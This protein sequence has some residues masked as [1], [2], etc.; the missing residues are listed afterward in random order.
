MKSCNP[1]LLLSADHH[2]KFYS[3]ENKF[4]LYS[5][6]DFQILVNH[7]SHLFSLHLCQAT[8]AP[9]MNV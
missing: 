6:S 1:S 2:N 4:V 7:L 3:V 8:Q 5:Q 9:E